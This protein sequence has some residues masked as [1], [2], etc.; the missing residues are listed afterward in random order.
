MKLPD[1]YLLCFA[2]GTVWSVATVLLGGLHFGHGH[3]HMHH[4]HGHTHATHG[5]AMGGWLAAMINPNSFA[6]FLAW[7]G[8]V[9][10]I[11]SRHT[12]LLLWIDLVLAMLFGIAG[13]WLLA[14][15]L[16]FLQRREQPLD[17]ADYEMVGVLGQVASPIRSDGVG[18][19]I[20]VRDGARRP[21]CARSED[22][23]YIGRGAEVVVTR[24][25]KGVAYVRTWE[26]MV[27]RSAGPEARAL[28]SSSSADKEKSHVD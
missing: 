3:A 8:G 10:Y 9:G 16:R 11:L 23:V 26:A 17:P 20:F 19:L 24:F 1:I 5:H 28:G 25:E 6:V 13:A 27:E 14:S 7:F 12:G 21:V 18:E 2:V 22:G 4:G 15:F